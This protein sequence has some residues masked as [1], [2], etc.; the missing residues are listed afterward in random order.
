LPTVPETP[1]AHPRQEPGA[2]LARA[3]PYQFQVAA[4]LRDAGLELTFAN[5]GGAG[6]VLQ[7]YQA[8]SGEPRFYTIG[9]DGY[10]TDHLPLETGPYAFEMH[11]PNGY[12]RTYRGEM[13]TAFAPAANGFFVPETGKFRIGLHNEGSAPVALEVRSTAYIEAPPR[14]HHLNPGASV[15]DDWD[16][17]ASHN[18]YDFIITCAEAPSFQR[19]L[20][21]HCENGKPSISDP[22]LGRQA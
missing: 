10:L 15:M 3:L 18:W 13:R 5:Y 9:K 4:N 7:L 11:G 12:L 6:I 21:G 2:R 1:E 20:A 14:L 22:L 8:S 16:L 19:R 17:S